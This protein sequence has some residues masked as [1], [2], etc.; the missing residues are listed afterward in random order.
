[1]TMS[2]IYTR[3]LASAALV[4]IVGCAEQPEPDAAGLRITGMSSY[5]LVVGESVEV[6]VR[7]LPEAREAAVTLRFEGEYATDDGRVEPVD[8]QLSPNYDG[9]GVHFDVP[10]TVFRVSRLGPFQ[11][12]FTASGR[13]GT[14]SGQVYITSRDPVG[15]VTQGTKP[16]PVVLDMGPSVIIEEFQPVD[17]QC[18]VP[19]VR[20]FPGL[21]YRLGVRAVGLKPVKFTYRLTDINGASGSVEFSHTFASPIERDVL[22][23]REEAILFNAIPADQQFY[24]SGLRV[25]VEDAEG[26]TVETA[27]PISVHRP[28]EVIN[29]GARHMAQRYEPVPASGCMPG[30]LGGMVTYS[31]A[32]TEY[33]QQSVNVTLRNEW[34]STRGATESETWQEG[35]S[36][37]TSQSRSLGGS[38]REDERLSE[39]HGL[40]Y[41][42][43]EANDMNYSSTDGETWNWNRREGESNTDYEDRLN[44]LYGEGNWSGTV[45]ATA[46]G[47][48][49]GFAKVTGKTST[50]VGVR[51][52]GSVGVTNGLSRS[53]SSDRGFGMSGT[54]SESRGFGSTLTENRSENVNGAYT[55][56]RSAATSHD[57]S[58]TRNESRTWD[59]SQ[60]ATSSNLVTDGT[61]DAESRT[62]SSSSSDTTVTSYSGALPISKVG[63][64]YRQT[65]RWV[66]RAEVRG[67]DQCGV[68]EHIGEIQF[69]EWTWAPDLAQ[70]NSCEDLPQTNLE[71]A[72]CFIEPCN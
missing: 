65:T 20:A 62:W 58:T 67:F 72:D 34:T 53:S 25:I 14:F 29:S 56:S 21:A 19:A 31:E 63:V 7:D 35:I 39:S 66:R 36:E 13:P 43:S 48:V 22:G 28:I 41:D 45:G 46:S 12:P 37:G 5:D 23:A 52:G 26:K 55:L 30:T 69:N 51:A 16:M 1:M 17:A 9:D 71:P 68:A 44:R 4:A 24:V 57:D 18:G 49:P 47:S 15:T 10:V 60:G 32:R 2:T 8:L 54:T 27:L 38:Q 33:R 64:F 42:S 3:F 11:N 61:S 59:F 6:F 50:T 40:R 70:S